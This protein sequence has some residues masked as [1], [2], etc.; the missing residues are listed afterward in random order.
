M[1]RNLVKNL[2]LKANTV[3]LNISTKFTKGNVIRC[4]FSLALLVLPLMETCQKKDTV[5]MGLKVLVET[6][7][8]DKNGA[9]VQTTNTGQAVNY[10]VSVDSV[11]IDVYRNDSI[12]GYIYSKKRKYT[13]A[14]YLPKGTY[15]LKIFKKGYF[16][17]TIPDIKIEANQVL[18]E[19]VELVH[20]IKTK[21]EE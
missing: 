3:Y 17:Q 13:G 16:P 1:K 4:L 12:I 7:S 15:T 8:L 14:L 18:Y 11:S 10:H 20:F 2:L 21:D 19:V 6:D 5:K 9:V